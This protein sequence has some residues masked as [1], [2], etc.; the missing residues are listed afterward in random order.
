MGICHKMKRRSH[1]AGTEYT[2]RIEQVLGA[3]PYGHRP[4]CNDGSNRCAVQERTLSLSTKERH[5][6]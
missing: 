4:A 3:T 2:P 6:R 5:A 1:T